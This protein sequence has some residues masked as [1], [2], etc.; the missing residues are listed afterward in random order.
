M[1]YNILQHNHDDVSYNVTHNY[2][3][4]SSEKIT[5]RRFNMI[6]KMK[7]FILITTDDDGDVNPVV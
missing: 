7:I 5:H 3:F 1:Y 4:V 6:C 2:Y